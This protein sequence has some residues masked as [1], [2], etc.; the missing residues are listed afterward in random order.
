MG[1]FSMHF[2]PCN[3]PRILF[4]TKLLELVNNMYL[5]TDATFICF[6]CSIEGRW[7]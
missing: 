6:L 1:S 5:L 3:V 7:D 4:V 2:D